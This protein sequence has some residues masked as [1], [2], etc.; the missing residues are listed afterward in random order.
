MC[1]S[2][3][4]DWM[5][6]RRKTHLT[7]FVGMSD[8]VDLFFM[9]WV[10]QSRERGFLGRWCIP[11]F[12]GFVSFKIHMILERKLIKLSSYLKLVYCY[13]GRKK[14]EEKEGARGL[15]EAKTTSLFFLAC[16]DLCSHISET[17]LGSMYLPCRGCRL[18]AH[19]VLN[20]DTG[21]VTVVM[22]WLLSK[23]GG[24]MRVTANLHIGI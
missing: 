9:H 15:I 13:L 2:L 12:M 20:W 8:W 11:L 22:S 21:E 6:E 14:G 10:R 18:L 5:W 16:P 7:Q 24:W 17:Y 1:Q 23:S 4:I 19:P 3:L